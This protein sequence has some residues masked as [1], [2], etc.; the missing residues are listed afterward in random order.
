VWIE[1]VCVWTTQVQARVHLCALAWTQST[2]TS[3]R[4]VSIRSERSGHPPVAF[5]RGVCW[6][7]CMKHVRLLAA[8]GLTLALLSILAACTP[9]DLGSEEIAFVRNGNLW[10]I[11][12][13]GANVFEAV[14]Q[15][16]PILGYGLSPTHQI[17][18]FRTLDS[19]FARTV[20]GTHLTVNP[21]TGLAGDA[22]SALSTV[23]I[24]GG[25]PI[26]LILS[27]PHLARSN[28]WWSP[29][30]TRLLY[31]EGAGPDL[32]SPALVSWI[33]S[34]NDQPEGIARKM[35]LESYS[36]PSINPENTLVVGNALQ[37][38]FTTTLSGTDLT[39]VQR[40]ALPN[41]PLPASLERVLWQPGHAHPALLYAI[42]P[43][44]GLV[45]LVLRTAGGQTRILANCHCFQFAWSPDG[46]QVLYS[47]PTGYTVL[48]LSSGSSF[49]FAAEHAAV[50]Y[51]SPD[52]QALLLDGEHTLTLVRLAERQVQVLLSDGQAPLMTDAPL[53]NPAAFLQ[54][55]ANS[56]WN[57]DGQRFVFATRGRT[58]WL[59][60]PLRPGDGLYTITLNTQGLTQSSPFAVDQNRQDTQPGWSYT[61][62]E[63]SFLF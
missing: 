58:R 20:A 6:P 60:L 2:P 22:P 40:G 33:V 37:G 31:R 27:T 8:L 25:T 19:T 5:W 30:G 29:T 18:V 48:D 61:E 42:M 26:P 24:D 39:S 36:I 12:P 9:G 10:T 16:T 43:A 54:P 23:G 11:T 51:W 49:P 32:G 7:V 57:I 56:L 44:G 63:T 3:G 53:P 14:A 35:L 45:H 1:G 17:F 59:G 38:I 50:P 55:V 34:Q 52:S 21:L 46:N 15:N 47:D 28:A 41:H 13:N 4:Q 62:P